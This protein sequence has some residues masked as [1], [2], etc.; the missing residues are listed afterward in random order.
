MAI[1][2]LTPWAALQHNNISIC[3]CDDQG[4]KVSTLNVTG[5]LTNKSFLM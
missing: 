5:I 1:L 4:A 2:A 3:C